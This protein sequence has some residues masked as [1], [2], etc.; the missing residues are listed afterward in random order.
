[1]NDDTEQVQCPRCGRE[2]T[3]VLDY[4]PADYSVGIFGGWVG[5]IA[6][7]DGDCF[8]HMTYQQIEDV[9]DEAIRLREERDEAE[10]AEV[11]RVNA[12]EID[13]MHALNA[14]NRAPVDWRSND[15]VPF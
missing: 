12:E 11:A 14:F 10:R 8:K 7:E 2:I 3:V 4:E 15:T 6:V 5:G 13:A 9:V 1:M